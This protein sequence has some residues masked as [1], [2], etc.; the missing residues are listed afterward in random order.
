MMSLVLGPNGS[1][2]S[3]IAEQLVRDAAQDH[4]TGVMVYLATLVPADEDGHA[5][6]AKHRKM[7]EGHDFLTVESPLADMGEV[8]ADV[9]LLEDVSNLLAN[10]TFSDQHP[11]PVTATLEQVDHLR[12]ACIHL[13]AV[14]I[15][16]LTV[17]SDFDGP[18]IVYID[19]LSQVNSRLILLADRVIDTREG[20]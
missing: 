15:G 11:D 6:V 19:A 7:R 3:A 18:T 4:P 17:E 1:G 13:I 10:F 9:I 5:R 16:G 14:T 2:K 20:T 12:Q 8:K